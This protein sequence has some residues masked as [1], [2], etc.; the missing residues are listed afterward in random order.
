MHVDESG[1]TGICT[2]AGADQEEG[3]QPQIVM[4]K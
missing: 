4:V 2:K 1:Y 3:A